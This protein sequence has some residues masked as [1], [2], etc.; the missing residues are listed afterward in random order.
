MDPA[1]IIGLTGSCLRLL[2]KV[3]L[4]SRQLNDV[5]KAIK[6]ADKTIVHLAAQLQLLEAV[7]SQLE[8]WLKQRQDMAPKLAQTLRKSL[9]ASAIILEDIN[10]HLQGVK[11]KSGEDSTTF[12]RKILLKWNQTE[13]EEHGRMISDQFQ[14]YALLVSIVNLPNPTTLIDAE[15]TRQLLDKGEADAMSIITA[16]DAASRIGT[17]AVDSG[18]MLDS[19]LATDEEIARSGPY[20]QN[21]RNLMRGVVNFREQSLATSSSLSLPNATNRPKD[22]SRSPSHTTPN[23]RQSKFGWARKLSSRYRELLDTLCNAVEYAGIDQV[24]KLVSEGADINGLSSRG[25]PL[26]LAISRGRTEVVRHLL[27]AGANTELGNKGQLPVHHAASLLETHIMELLFQHG[28]N[29]QALSSSG[30][31]AL[32]HAA[33][34][35]MVDL[36]IEHGVDVME[37]DTDGYIALMRAAWRGD[38][39]ALKGL[40]RHSSPAAFVVT[41]RVKNEDNYL[42]TPLLVAVVKGSGRHCVEIA[43]WLIAHGADVHRR[44]PATKVTIQYLKDSNPPMRNF[45]GSCAATTSIEEHRV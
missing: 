4:T 18:E 32:H 22:S 36:L 15:N 19:E 45:W 24:K 42:D 16:K 25:T 7:L 20:L 8:C 37:E 40:L 17:L 33:T 26:L 35:A 21:Y 44:Y 23:S 31:T 38:V 30:S 6:N 28:A 9:A 2:T 13:L 43:T 29:P 39:G 14:A 3:V 1:S 12:G 41:K 34:E 11:P 5:V 27:E 10:K